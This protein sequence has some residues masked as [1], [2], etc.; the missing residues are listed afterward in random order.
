MD[1]GL[2]AVFQTME[3]VIFLSGLESVAVRNVLS[4]ATRWVQ[5]PSIIATMDIKTHAKANAS[6]RREMDTIM[7]IK[8]RNAL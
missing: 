1:Q 5:T 2:A 3:A 8:Q 4:P 6:V 7:R